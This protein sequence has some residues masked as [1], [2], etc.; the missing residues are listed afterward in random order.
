[1][2]RTIILLIALMVPMFGQSP[3]YS[4]PFIFGGEWSSAM[5]IHNL[6]DATISTPLTYFVDDAEMSNVPLTIGPRASW[7][8]EF[9]RTEAT[10]TGFI[11]VVPNCS[12]CVV[13]TIR[14]TYHPPVLVEW[15]RTDRRSTRGHQLDGGPSSD[16]VAPFQNGSTSFTVLGSGNDTKLL[17]AN[18]NSVPVSVSV[19]KRNGTG[20]VEA[21]DTFTLRANQVVIRDGIALG[22]T[23]IESTGPVVLSAI[24][25]SVDA[26]VSGV[27]VW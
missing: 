22:S 6:T 5:T 18:P 12:A 13:A 19:T 11:R 4:T 10:H 15:D 8:I 24:A 7:T 3:L 1:M 16:A 20:L 27:P 25:V 26:V 23:V 17:L 21:V 9:P 2:L 14:N